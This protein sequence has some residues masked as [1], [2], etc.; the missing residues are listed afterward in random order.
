VT[1]RVVTNPGHSLGWDCDPCDGPCRLSDAYCRT[2]GQWVGLGPD[3]ARRPSVS[4][5][6]DE[7]EKLVDQAI[8]PARREAFLAELVAILERELVAILERAGRV[9]ST[10]EDPR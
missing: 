3:P 5:A 8:E 4:T 6:A 2:C 10:P 1:R 9:T 7:I